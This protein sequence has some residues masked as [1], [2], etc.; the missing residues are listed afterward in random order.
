M[1]R[2]TGVLAP[3]GPFGMSDSKFQRE[4]RWVSKCPPS[5]RQ[6]R[7]AGCKGLLLRRRMPVAQALA[8]KPSERWSVNTKSIARAP[9]QVVLGSQTIKAFVV[10]PKRFN[11]LGIVRIGMEYGLLA[12]NEDGSYLRVNGSVEMALETVEVEHAIR[13]A[14]AGGAGKP[15]ASSNFCH[16]PQTP[17]VVFRKH[18]HAQLPP[19]HLL[20]KPAGRV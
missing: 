14:I 20:Q 7:H 19:G 13:L 10:A 18:R 17:S 3:S 1:P 16:A 9:L 2:R 8:N 12:L 4:F 11:I 5:V 6:G 15:H